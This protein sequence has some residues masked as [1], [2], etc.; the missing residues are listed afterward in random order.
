MC[1]YSGITSDLIK[2]SSI[3]CATTLELLGITCDLIKISSI[4]RATTLEL[5]V[6]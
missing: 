2:I 1:H 5:L 6:I 3:E 4:E